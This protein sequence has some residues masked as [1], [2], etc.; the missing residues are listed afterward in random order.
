M[1]ATT[2]DM[3]SAVASRDVAPPSPCG[4][5][6]DRER[7]Q[8][9]QATR[10]QRIGISE[11]GGRIEWPLH[12]DWPGEHHRAAMCVASRAFFGWALQPSGKR[13]RAG[14]RGA[15][16]C[17]ST[18]RVRLLTAGVRRMGLVFPLRRADKVK[19]S[20]RRVAE[21][22]YG[23]GDVMQEQRHSDMKIH[24]PQSSWGSTSMYIVPIGISFALPI[25]SR[26]LKCARRTC[27]P[28]RAARRCSP[29]RPVCRHRPAVRDP[30]FFSLIAVGLAHGFYMIGKTYNE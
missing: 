2:L 26:T 17:E 29:S 28:R 30:I 25:V 1:R 15:C 10:L 8:A 3:H 19:E 13:V 22:E 5:G 4:R 21:E 9:V 23:E 20:Y 16:L 7:G 18:R 14:R 11:K 27:R 6:E 24:A 12:E